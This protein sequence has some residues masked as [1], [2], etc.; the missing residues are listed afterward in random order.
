M[1][2][3]YNLETSGDDIARKQKGTRDVLPDR[4]KVDMA[5]K[6]ALLE[7]SANPL[8][9]LLNRMGKQSTHDFRFQWMDDKLATKWGK[10][11]NSG[12]IG[13]EDAGDT[14]TFAVEDPDVFSKG[15]TIKFL[16]TGEQAVVTNISGNDI[17]VERGVDREDGDTCPAITDETDILI[18]FN[19]SEQGAEKPTILHTRPELHYNYTEI[20]RTALGITETLNAMD[21]HGG[22]D[23]KY[24]RM[25]KGIEHAIAI[26]RKLWFGKRGYKYS[27]STGEPTTWTRGVLDWLEEGGANTLEATDGYLDPYAFND[28][29]I[30]EAFRYGNKNGKIMFCGPTFMSL[31]QNWG[32]YQ[33]QTSTSEKTWGMAI[34]NVLTPLGS[35][36]MINHPEFDGEYR[37]LCVI[38]EVGELKYRYLKGRDTKLVKNR[39]NPSADA[40]IEEYITEMGLELKAFK[41]H[42]MVTGVDSSVPPEED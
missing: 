30:E 22:N 35:I 13:T 28:W 21:L 27:A 32:L 6:I 4:R 7:P 34:T 25:K 24:R 26:E 39:Q 42:S 41:K 8:T 31:I 15:Y 23:L 18:L 1:S 19:T 17:T 36:P 37:G 2:Q 38:L 40:Q 9:L 14:T 11:D 5:S 29:L 12:E 16:D 10:I 20:T 3:R 33:L